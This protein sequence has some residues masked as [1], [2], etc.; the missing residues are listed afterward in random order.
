MHT[1]SA[2][3][4]ALQFLLAPL[5]IGVIGRTK[6]AFAGRR[7]APFLQP[8]WDMAK[9]AGKGAVYS[10]TTTWVFKA[11][12][13]LGL[14]AFCTAS[15]LVPSGKI[16]A[17]MAFSGDFL[18]MAALLAA[19]RFATMAAALDTGSSF[20]GMGASREAQFSALCEPALLVS[21]AVLARASGS[22]SLSSIFPSLGRGA[23][24]VSGPELALCATALA[25]VYLAENARIPVDDPATH[26][27]LTMIHEVMVLD[28]CGPDFAMIL[29]GS[30][31]KLWLL[32]ALVTGIL[33]PFD[34]GSPWANLGLFVGAQFVLAI[35]VGVV[36]SSMA[37]L[38]L[39]RVPQL[40][41]GAGILA[42]LSL[43][44]M[45]G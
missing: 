29:Y 30:T 32:G 8:Y 37:R 1:P 38:R 7:G 20:E 23:W 27:E 21:F 3:A 36:E 19:A 39:L 33:L 10:T 45:V 17:L 40:L 34:L 43:V 24:Q 44:L 4:L 31:L 42:C 9:L 26:L 22:L 18:V 13:A 5:L 15:L 35:A 2:V 6:A 41:V 11:G 25:V 14:A 28:H 12:P 16:P